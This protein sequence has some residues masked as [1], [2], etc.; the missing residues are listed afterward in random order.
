[1]EPSSEHSSHVSRERYRA[2]RLGVIERLDDPY[3]TDDDRWVLRQ[4]LRFLS[5]S[6]PEPDR[7]VTPLRAERDSTLTR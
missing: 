1:M 7:R 2:I 4:F 6:A 3:L 5:G